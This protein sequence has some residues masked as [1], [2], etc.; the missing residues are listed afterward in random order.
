MHL[1]AFAVVAMVCHRE[2]ALR[3]PAAAQLTRYYLWISLGGALGGMFNALLAPA[4]FTQI[5]EF[6]LMLAAA[7]FLRPTPGWR[8]RQLEPWAIVLGIPVL[9]FVVS[10]TASILQP[11]PGVSLGLLAAAFWFCAGLILGFA[12]R[13]QP[14]AIAAVALAVAYLLN[15]QQPGQ[16]VI[17]AARTFFGVHRVLEDTPPTQHRLTHGT[18][19]HGWQNLADR[20]RCV[21]TSYYYP[22]GPIGQ[23]F[24]AFGGR[25]RRVGVIGL[26]AGGLVCYGQPGARWTY[27]EIDPMVE[28]I[29]SDPAFF[30]FLANSRAAVDVVVG[31]GRLT[32]GRADP[33]TFDVI[34]ADAFSSDAVPMHLLTREFLASAL[35][36]LREGGVLAIHIS[37]VYFDLEPVVAA[38]L[39]SLGAS[40]L[41]QYFRSPAADGLDSHWLVAARTPADLATVA[42]DTRWQ[43][44]RVGDRIWTDDRSNILDAINWR[45]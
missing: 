31:D 45:R 11:T 4:I 22:T 10:L 25:A 27:Y 24:D 16:R 38:S 3:R 2:L 15:P 6:P 34:V 44:P 29:A 7:A 14:F 40:S 28:R 8:G 20:D 23:L 35:D 21:P 33:G 5:V 37:N 43:P 32:L 9:A 1:A 18:T 17:F 42:A 41:T 26:G 30:S 13:P 19:L 36:R 39:K 12:N